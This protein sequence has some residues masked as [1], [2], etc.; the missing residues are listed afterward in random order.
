MAF[1][2]KL[3]AAGMLCLG[4]NPLPHIIDSLVTQSSISEM[5]LHYVTFS[6]CRVTR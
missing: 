3:D 4:I 5:E 2:D 1:F 6:L